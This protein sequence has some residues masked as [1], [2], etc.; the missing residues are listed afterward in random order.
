MTVVQDLDVSDCAMLST[1]G[2][3]AIAALTQLTALHGRSMMLCDET[4]I[5]R[6]LSATNVGVLN[7]LCSLTGDTPR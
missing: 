4:S 5:H 7:L 6:M 2:L 1:G 3:Q